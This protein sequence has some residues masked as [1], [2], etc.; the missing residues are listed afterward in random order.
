[1]AT[2]QV[3]NLPDQTVREWKVRA[4]RS[5]KSL[6]EYM[7][8]YLVDEASKPTIDEVL[9]RLSRRTAELAQGGQARDLPLD[10][11]LRGV[12]ETWG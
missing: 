7:R 11:T 8:G 9:D 5:G 4:A 3:R 12:D 6:Q 1:M 10:E 2:I